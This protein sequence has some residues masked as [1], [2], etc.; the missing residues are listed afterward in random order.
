M[1]NQPKCNTTGISAFDVTRL[2]V[3]DIVRRLW[4]EYRVL[5]TATHGRLRV[6]TPYFALEDEIDALA[7]VLSALS[8]G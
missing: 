7:D 1:P 8:D 2:D 3:D 6:S 4:D 5:V